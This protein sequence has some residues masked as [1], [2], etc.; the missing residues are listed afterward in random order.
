MNALV[1][2]N[3]ILRKLP[4]SIFSQDSM[5]NADQPMIDEI[6]AEDKDEAMK[7]EENKGSLDVLQ[8]NLK[9]LEEINHQH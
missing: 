5:Q 8:R 7:R 3:G 9:I 1:V 2:E 6:A 4:G